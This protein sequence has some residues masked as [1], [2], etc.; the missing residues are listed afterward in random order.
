MGSRLKSRIWCNTCSSPYRYWC[1]SN[2]WFCWCMFP[3][4]HCIVVQVR[5]YNGAVQNT[6]SCRFAWEGNTQNRGSQ[7]KGCN[8]VIYST[9]VVIQ[10]DTLLSTL[11]IFLG[12]WGVVMS[13]TR[14]YLDLERVL[15]E[16]FSPVQE[17]IAK[18]YFEGQKLNLLAFL[19][20]VY[21]NCFGIFCCNSTRRYS[22]SQNQTTFHFKS[23]F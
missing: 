17:N 9:W 7:T 5:W 22:S 21:K 1:S 2:G 10:M 4:F 16:R 3:V 19:Q 23:V 14:G 13:L 12:L 20:S 6:A 15:K 8:D 11:S 18:N